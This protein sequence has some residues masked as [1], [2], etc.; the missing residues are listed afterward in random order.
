MRGFISSQFYLRQILHS[1]D[2]F[3]FSEHWLF[4]EQLDLITEFSEIYQCYS[5]SSNNNP[6]FLSGRRGQGGVGLFLKNE[7][8]D[9]ITH[10]PI[11]SDRI[12]SVQFS[13]QLIDMPVDIFIFSVHFPSTNYPIDEY[14]ECFSLLWALF[15][16]Y[17]DSGPII[18]LGNLNG[19]W[20]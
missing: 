8:G 13:F 4:K 19:S 20:E 5:I 6:N 10:L 2:M 7:Y 18:I 12:V 9:L 11:D 16:T 17:C 15:E 3:A 14:K 1:F